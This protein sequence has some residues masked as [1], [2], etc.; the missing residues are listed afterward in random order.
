[1]PPAATTFHNNDRF[2]LYGL[3]QGT[4]QQL[5]CCNFCE[6]KGATYLVSL[7]LHA[8][9]HAWG[10]LQDKKLG[11]GRAGWRFH[12]AATDVLVC[13]N[14]EYICPMASFLWQNDE[15]PMDLGAS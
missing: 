5:D 7:L 12:F 9:V 1:M 4:I 8:E 10:A 14:M 3:I 15:Q 6:A 11:Q 13:L 2:G